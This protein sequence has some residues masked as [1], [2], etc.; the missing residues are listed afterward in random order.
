M[1]QIIASFFLAFALLYGANLLAQD[2]PTNREQNI[3]L[4]LGSGNDLT[5]FRLEYGHYWGLGERGRFKIGLGLRAHYGLGSDLRMAIVNTTNNNGDGAL[6][7]DAFVVSNFG[8]GGLNTVLG[9]KYSFNDKWDLGLKFDVLGLGFGAAQGG[10]F[11]EQ[12]TS[13]IT[14]VDTK[15]PNPNIA[16]TRG[17][18]MS[19]NLWLGYTLKQKHQIILSFAFF[20]TEYELSDNSALNL[21]DPRFERIHQMLFVG[22]NFRF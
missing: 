5:A 12:E 15:S 11:T 13:E 2:E 3:G 4:A 1:K 8:V 18:V 6:D 20:G 17:Q 14:A 22:Y 21:E 9:I 10:D 16:F 19:D 7:Q